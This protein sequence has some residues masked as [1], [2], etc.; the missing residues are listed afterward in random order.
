MAL[1]EARSGASGWLT[2]QTMAHLL[3]KR[4]D[5]TL[6]LGFDTKSPSGSTAGRL[7]GSDTFGHLGF[8]GTSLWC[9]PDAEIVTALLTNRVR[10]TRANTSIRAAR[11]TIHDRLF[12]KAASAVRRGLVVANG[13]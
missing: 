7:S 2:A 12:G 13:Q 11:P 4:P 6:G 10:P 3:A 8:T 5:T 1:I 9:D